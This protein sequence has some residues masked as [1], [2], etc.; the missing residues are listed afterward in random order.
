MREFPHGRT[1]SLFVTLL[2]WT[3]PIVGWATGEW[4]IGYAIVVGV[5]GV[6]LANLLL[7]WAIDRWTLRDAGERGREG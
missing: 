3:A 6:V 2:A 4:Q 5:V 7:R 1:L